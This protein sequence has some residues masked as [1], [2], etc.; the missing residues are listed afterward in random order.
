MGILLAIPEI[1]TAAVVGGAE[2]LEIAGSAGAIATGEGLATLAGLAESAGVVGEAVGGTLAEQA[3]ALGVSEAAYTVLSQTPQLVEAAGAIGGGVSAV[4][5]VAGGLAAYFSPDTGAQTLTE[6]AA[7]GGS[8]GLPGPGPSGPGHS[9]PGTM[10]VALF[11]QGGYNVPG[12]PDWVIDLIPQLPFGLHEVPDL[13]H[14]IAYGIWTSYYHTG[15]EI[16]QRGLSEELQRLLGD[17]RDGVQYSLRS[18]S[19]SDPVQAIIDTLSSAQE[20]RR[21]QNAR[22][23]GQASESTLDIGEHL[24]KLFEK[25]SSAISEAGQAAGGTAY[26]VANMGI[27]GLNTLGDGLM[28]M[29]QWVTFQGATGGTAHHSVPSWFWYLLN[30]LEVNFPYKVERASLKRIGDPA[31]DVP[32]RKRTRADPSQNDKKRRR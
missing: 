10:A 16:I 9:K 2:A 29:G 7:S 14:R 24:K 25:V 6:Q 19:E 18:L 13:I 17:L 28:R 23:I 3:A 12:I 11:P 31:E 21:I 1:I 5:S 32:Q 27:D 30:E 8:S 15:R 26:D 4:S 22:L 20:T